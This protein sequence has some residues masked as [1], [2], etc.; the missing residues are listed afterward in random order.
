MQILNIAGYKFITLTD[1][2]TLQ[3]Y[4][5]QIGNDLALKGT[6]L[7]SSEGIN[8]SLAGHATH[9]SKFKTILQNNEFF[10][11]IVF[12]ESYSTHLPFKRFKVKIKDEII[13]FRQ[14]HIQPEK[15]RVQNI[16]PEQFKQWLDEDRDI[17]VL[18]TRNAYEVKFG[19]FKKAIHL[20][21]KDFTEFGEASKHLKKDKPIVM[22]C[23]G[24][25]RCE[26]AGLHLLNN[27]YSEVFQLEGGILNYFAKVNG[28]H[29]NG[30][31]FVF[32]ERISLDSNLEITGTTQCKQCQGPIKPSEQTCCSAC[33]SHL[34]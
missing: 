25:I 14:S 11:D 16:T 17:T 5:Q 9:L 4:F 3:T 13:T 8:L 32:D 2:L 24:G 27:G 18:D 19:A 23:T 31:C 26:K 12:R 1:L 10:P 29:Y 6:I 7:L 22:Y 28:S 21:T 30:E 33:L 20:N 15:Q 34:N